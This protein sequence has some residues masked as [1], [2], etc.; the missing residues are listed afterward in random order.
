MPKHLPAYP[1]RFTPL[2][3]PKVWGAHRMSRWR[4]TPLPP[5]APGGESWEISDHPHGMSVVANGPLA[6]RTFHDLLQTDP[7]A[8]AGPDG[9]TPDGRFLF[10]FKFLDAGAYTSVQV[11]PDDAYAR[12][13]ESDP[14]GKTEAWYI[15]HAEPGA[16]LIRGTRP[17]IDLAAFKRAL[18]EGHVERTLEAFSVHS[19]DVIDLPAGVLHALGPGITLAEIQQNSDTTYRVFDWNRKGLDGESRQLHLDQALDV[20]RFSDIGPAIQ[21]RKTL[22]AANPLHQNLLTGPLF[23]MDRLVHDV[24]FELPLRHAQFDILA[25]IS[26]RGSLSCSSASPE[27][28]APGDSIFLPASLDHAVLNPNPSLELLWIRRP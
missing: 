20:L 18:K 23:V 28:L 2:V 7:F 22:S 24:P 9:L 17:G 16:K 10:L 14:S 21:P 5:H 8:I 11:H 19:G 26:G 3:M 13:H 25:T 27:T 15:I 4:N 6:G 12:A 1:L